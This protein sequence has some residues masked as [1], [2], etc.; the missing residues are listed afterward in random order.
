MTRSVVPKKLREMVVAR[1]E[2]SCDRC[3][4]QLI[5]QVYSLQHRR[6]RGAGGRA[7][8]HTPANL[9]VLCGTANTPG[10]CHN[11]AENTGE[12]RAEAYALGFA[13]R[14]EARAPEDV[15][16]FRHLREWVIP[17]DGVWIP[18]SDPDEQAAA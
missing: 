15:P 8:A 3:A 1:A 6:A 16:I 13:I 9:I 4:R 5:G 14:G 10:S 7:G 12:G 17:G 2:Y 11:F 18:S